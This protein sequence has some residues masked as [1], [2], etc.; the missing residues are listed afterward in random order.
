MP[1]KLLNQRLDNRH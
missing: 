1:S